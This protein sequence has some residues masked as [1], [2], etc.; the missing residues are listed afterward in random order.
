M[1]VHRAIALSVL[2]FALTACSNPGYIRAD[3]GGPAPD[4][5][6]RAKGYAG[7]ER[8]QQDIATVF[9]TDAEPRWGATYICTVNS[10]ALAKPGCAHVVYLR[11]GIHILGWK[12]RGSTAT[13]HGQYEVVVEAGRVYQ[14]NASPLGGDRGKV[15]LIPMSVGAKLTHR[16]VMPNRIP[17]GVHP[18]DPVPYGVD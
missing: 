4:R 1:R 18:D 15:Q 14:L 12:Y 5:I 16:N 10:H 3:G 2:F 6:V 9:A 13:G 8:P 7:A 17:A 11:P